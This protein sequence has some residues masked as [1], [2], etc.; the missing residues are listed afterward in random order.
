M[1]WNLWWRF[2]DWRARRVAVLEWLRRERPDVCGLQEVWSTEDENLAG[3][4]A[5]ELGMHWAWAPGEVFAHWRGRVPGPPAGVGNAV[6]SRWPIADTEVRRLPTAEGPEEVRTALFALVEAPGARLPFFTTHLHSDPAGSA[7]RL[8]QVAALAGFV[9]E[10]RGG[11]P[12]PPVI[13]GD[14]NA[15]PDS[16]EL[17][18]FGGTL[19]EPAVPGQ[20]LLDAWRFAAP[21]RPAATWE[22]DNPLVSGAT[23][24]EARIDYIHVGP[25]GPAGEGRV[26]GVRRTAA[27]PAPAG[28]GAWPSDHAAVVAE[29]AGA[30]GPA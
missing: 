17:R 4:L 27:G 29:L 24:F 5:E 10:R 7:V 18:L 8:A 13:T 16:D 2:G 1:T 6:L 12:F 14:F 25:P 9:A 20:L 19:T 28:T 22:L 26:T 3:W 30:G 11:T 21:D 15:E 23:A